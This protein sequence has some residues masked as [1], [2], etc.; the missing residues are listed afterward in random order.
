MNRSEA[1]RIFKEIVNASENVGYNTF[2]LKISDK[3]DPKAENYQ[4]HIEM[5]PDHFVKKQIASLAKKHQLEV[6][7]ENGRIVIYQ[8]KKIA[9]F[10]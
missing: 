1:V 3:N 2:N 9:N 6:R 8:P 4:I 5:R 10:V 7:E